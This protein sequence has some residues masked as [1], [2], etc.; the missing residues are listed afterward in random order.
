MNTNKRRKQTMKHA[1]QFGKEK[2]GEGGGER[3]LIIRKAIKREKPITSIL[4]GPAES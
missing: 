1:A 2:A 4:A 3:E